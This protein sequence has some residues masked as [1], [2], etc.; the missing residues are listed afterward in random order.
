MFSAGIVDGISLSR[1]L[2][3]YPFLVGLA[4]TVIQVQ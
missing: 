3:V 4:G 2:K 1:H